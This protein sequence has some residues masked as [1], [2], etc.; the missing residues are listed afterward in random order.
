MEL[1][2]RAGLICLQVLQ[3]EAPHQ[4]ILAPDVLRDKVY[5]RPREQMEIKNS[6]C[7]PQLQNCMCK[8][9]WMKELQEILLSNR[10][11]LWK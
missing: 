2:H 7:K 8:M 3:V 5:L 10:A 11:L 6:N 9:S 4:E 1:C